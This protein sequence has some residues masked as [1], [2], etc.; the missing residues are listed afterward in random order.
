MQGAAIWLLIMII[1]IS[2]KRNKFFYTKFHK[3]L[4]MYKLKFVDDLFS[5]NA[6][7]CVLARS[8]FVKSS[9]NQ[10]LSLYLGVNEKSSR[11]IS[12]LDLKQKCDL[13]RDLKLITSEDFSYINSMISIRNIFVHR[14]EVETFTDCYNLNSQLFRHF[15]NK[16]QVKFIASE[17]NIRELFYSLNFKVLSIIDILLKKNISRNVEEA[18]TKKSIELFQITI[19]IYRESIV[20]VFNIHMMEDKFPAQEMKNSY[21]INIRN[22]IFELAKIKSRSPK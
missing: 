21:L 12:S 22:Q 5:E 20:E 6:R 16:S 2:K 1:K 8:L 15:I 7:H 4:N 18:I 14:L 19:D 10:H 11:I 13:L 17:Q 9:I 3:G